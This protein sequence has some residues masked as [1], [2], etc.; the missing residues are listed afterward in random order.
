M[1]RKNAAAVNEEGDKMFG[2]DA[3]ENEE[4]INFNLSK[5]DELGQVIA[6]NLNIDKNR[7]IVC[8]LEKFKEH[9][10]ELDRDELNENTVFFICQDENKSNSVFCILKL[11]E[12]FFCLYADFINAQIPKKIETE[13]K[14]FHEKIQLKVYFYKAESDINYLIM[15]TLE[16][17]MINTKSDLKKNFIESFKDPQKSILKKIMGKMSSFKDRLTSY[18][19]Q[20]YKNMFTS[21][22]DKLAEEKNFLKAL[23]DFM[24]QIPLVEHD[25]YNE[26]LQKVAAKQE[27]EEKGDDIKKMIEELEEARKSLFDK[28]SKI[29]KMNGQQTEQQIDIYRKFPN[30]MKMF[31]EI[32]EKLRYNER[33]FDVD[34]QI[35]KVSEKLELDILTL[36]KYF[37][38]KKISE[39]KRDTNNDNERGI[40]KIIESLP[41]FVENLEDD[42]QNETFEQLIS[43]IEDALKGQKMVDRQICKYFDESYKKVKN[44]YGLWKNRD[45]KEVFD[46]AREKKLNNLEICEAIAVMDRANSLATGGHNLRD[47]QI[48]SILSF[49][50]HQDKGLLAQIHTGEGKTTVVAILAA[51]KALQGKSVDIITSNPILASD[52][53]KSKRIFYEILGLSV[54][55]NNLNEKYTTGERKCYKADIV[56]GS[57]GNFQF[58]YLKDSFLGYKTR[59]GRKFDTIILDEVDSMIIDNASHIAKLSGSIPGMD[60]LK[61]V[62][63]KIWMKLNDAEEEIEN[64]F[65]VESERKRQELKANNLSDDESQVLYNEFVAD[66]G[67]STFDKIIEFV[68]SANPCDIKFIPSHI[69]EYAKKALDKW[70]NSALDAKYNYKQN[71]QYV[72]PET[73]EKVIQ[74]VDYSN[75]GVTLKNTIWQNGLH[76]FLQ[77]KHCLRLTSESLTSCF[78][79][80][81]SYI[82]KYGKDIYGLTGTLGSEAE[83]DLMSSIYNV[84]FIKIPTYKERKFI[85]YE[86]EVVDDRFFI[87]TVA[88]DALSMAKS[89]RSCLVICETIKDAKM[90]EDELRNKISNSDLKTFFFE[91]D[92][93]VT[94]TIVEP[95]TV[96]IATNIA[97]RGTDLETSKDLE[98]N[99]GLHVCVA[100]L[101]CNKRVEDQA[102]GRTARQGKRG[103][104]QM[105]IKRSEVSSMKISSYNTIKLI[106]S[107][108]DLKEKLRVKQLKHGKIGELEY[109]DEL[110]ELFSDLYNKTKEKFIEKEGSQYVLEDLKEFWAFWLVDQDFNQEKLDKVS[111]ELLFEDFKSEA[112][113]TIEGEITFNPYYSIRQGE[114]FTLAGNLDEAENSLRH[115]INMTENP[116]IMYSAYIKLFEISLQ[117]G[118]VVMNKFKN[119]LG[120]ILG[121]KIR[122][123]IEKCFE[124]V[125]MDRQY[126]K[127]ALENLEEAKQAL[128]NEINY[129]QK[130]MDSEEFRKILDNAAREDQ[131]EQN[132]ESDKS[133]YKNLFL[134]HFVSRQTA[135]RLNMEHS[136]SLAQQITEQMKKNSGDISIN[137]RISDLFVKLEPKSEE[138]EK[139]KETVLKEELSELAAVGLNINYN[140]RETHD[141]SKN[142]M[143][144]AKSQIIGGLAFCACPLTIPIGTT[145]ISEGISDIATELIHGTENFSWDA[146]V[147][148]K[149]NS[150]RTALIIGVVTWGFGAI[151]RCKTIFEKAEK[152]LRSLAKFLRSVEGPLKGVCKNLATYIDKLA[153]WCRNM[154]HLAKFN[155]LSTAAQEMK[156][157][158]YAMDSTKTTK[159]NLLLGSFNEMKQVSNLS[160]FRNLSMTLQ[161]VAITS[162]KQI[163][164]GEV[165][166]RIVTPIVGKLMSSLKPT[167]VEK[168]KNSVNENIDKEKMNFNNFEDIHK[169]L[170]E[171]RETVGFKE[172][173]V[174][175]INASLELSKN[176][177]NWRVQIASLVVDQL[178]IWTSVYKFTK[179]MCGKLNEKLKSSSESVKNSE[180]EVEE[181]VE[182]ICALFS[183][184]LYQLIVTTTIKTTKDFYT[185][186]KSAYKNYQNETIEIA[187]CNEKIEEF[188]EYGPTGQEEINAFCDVE[189]RPLHIC[190]EHG[191]PICKLRDDG[192][193][194]GEPMKVVYFPPDEANPNGHYVP[195]GKDK[196]WSNSS[197][198]NN[199]FFDAVAASSGGYPTQMR[200]KTVNQMKS[201]PQRYIAL[202]I[203][204]S[205][206]TN[207]FLK[208]G[209]G[210]EEF[211]E[212][213]G[214]LEYTEDSSDTKGIQLTQDGHAD[215][216]YDEEKA[217]IVSLELNETKTIFVGDVLDKTNF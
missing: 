194:S 47:T 174:V 161:N 92:A 97:G 185:V 86:G 88:N 80:N 56:Y 198:K 149:V 204:K 119:V 84:Q 55:A 39:E 211:N 201:N 6:E 68:K 82:K 26:L 186:G 200:D 207:I 48:L 52:C 46:W 22:I 49:T 146:Y 10:S 27:R 132:E 176:C 38:S 2:E 35:I 202:N 60:S 165:M 7:L 17:M 95:G 23:K 96:L 188:K 192:R 136:E 140:M 67:E 105:L 85:E 191:N 170:K 79:S 4:N 178:T 108:R 15:L 190:D 71:V 195:I 127:K 73:G 122:D 101:P 24:S 153:G 11:S 8:D 63:L 72:I 43:D 9:L 98:R 129:I 131:E 172:I 128:Q 123:K 206:N 76:Q 130:L 159:Y 78:I 160:Y 51:I 214:E 182:K 135:L 184:E 99:G 133:E 31:D 40:A 93:H 157:E 58:D 109:Q 100:F 124:S 217:K 91:E 152:V 61:Y 156:L 83:K 144:G 59:A 29:Q 70:I 155:K 142:V 147:K 104:A 112:H 199:C 197:G 103:T 13:L 94:K 173:L 208:G 41:G 75:T 54:D 117:Q 32:F 25:H 215:V 166:G 110:F 193:Y 12:E 106:K 81:L 36:K 45:A 44:F 205:G 137:G 169:A 179:T 57:I 42:S 139:I 213:E 216:H 5:I 125:K 50:Y 3:D 177:N 154:K 134:K 168:V 107:M 53:I 14:L 162:T 16:E 209:Q 148:G 145:M 102:F 121:D 65:K 90:V 171:I 181:N 30:Q 28:A 126:K 118:G 34:D 77:L 150:Y 167:V 37:K 111:H 120:E 163:V 187:K 183:D 138:E 87:S 1:N 210:P 64:H 74:P 18:T 114:Y 116:E 62:Y 143:I 203:H 175:V 69:K 115:A 66:F 113:K 141:V 19:K 189:E 21:N 33:R 196:T 151:M 164:M 158:K 89:K 212:E 20:T 180:T